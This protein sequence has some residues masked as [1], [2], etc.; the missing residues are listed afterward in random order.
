M[1]KHRITH[2]LSDEEAQRMLDAAFVHYRE[3][4]PRYQPT[5]I[6]H[7]PKRAELR[8]HVPGYELAARLS[9]HP[10]EVLIELDLPFLL[11]PFEKR[12]RERI[13][14]EAAHWLSRSATA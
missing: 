6:W 7:H 5:L 14:R 9:L 4:Y 8:V 1:V 12:A 2:S 10:H 11:R 3:R 13:D